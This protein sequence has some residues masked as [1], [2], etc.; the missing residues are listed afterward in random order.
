M[1]KKTRTVLAFKR[2]KMSFGKRD[3]TYMANQPRSRNGPPIE[4]VGKRHQQPRSVAERAE[5]DE[6]VRAMLRMAAARSALSEC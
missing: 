4:E 3:L 2:V 5:K 1:P 6:S